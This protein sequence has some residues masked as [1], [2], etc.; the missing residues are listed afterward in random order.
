[1]GGVRK[2]KKKLFNL[3][4]ILKKKKIIY[5]PKNYLNYF[6]SFLVNFFSNKITFLY[7]FSDASHQQELKKYKILIKRPKSLPKTKK[8]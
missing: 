7:I 2:Y 4:K 5:I 1:M 8:N 6:F 3:K